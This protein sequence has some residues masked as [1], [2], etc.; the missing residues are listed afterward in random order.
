M[1]SHSESSSDIAA[2][3]RISRRLTGAAPAAGIAAG[4]DPPFIRFRA[5][6]PQPQP[7]PEPLLPEPETV[8]APLPPPD[9]VPQDLES[10][11]E[12]LTWALDHTGGESAFVVDSQGFVIAHCGNVPADGFEGSGAELCLAMEQLDQIDGE[13]QSLRGV[14]LEFLSRR[15]IAMRVQSDDELE[16]IVAI[17]VP[18]SLSEVVRNAIWRQ[19]VYSLPDLS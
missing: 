5:P 8:A 18:N 3:G 12:F 4:S 9:P 1:T 2:A 11:G 15:I 13:N 17:E 7:E 16:V 14:E 6:Q 19:A 10:W